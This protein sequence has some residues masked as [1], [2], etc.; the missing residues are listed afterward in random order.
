MVGQV[1][2]QR[3]ALFNFMIEDFPTTVIKRSRNITGVEGRSFDTL[4]EIDDFRLAVGLNDEV[5]HAQQLPRW[6][7]WSEGAAK[8]RY[9][10]SNLVWSR[11]DEPPL[12]N[13]VPGRRGSGA[14]L[15]QG[16]YPRIKGSFVVIKCYTFSN[17]AIYWNIGKVLLVWRPAFIPIPSL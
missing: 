3:E 12:I 4:V 1:V 15:R 14:H 13:Y 16:Q 11:Q 7:V 6:D 17:S 10:P 2:A 5:R 8:F 9:D